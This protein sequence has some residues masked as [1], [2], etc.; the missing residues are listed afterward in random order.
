MDV[1]IDKICEAQQGN[2]DAMLYLIQKYTPLLMRYSKKIY[3]EDAFSELTLAFIELIYHIKIEKLA[4]GSDGVITN[5][6]FTSIKNTYIAHIKEI[7]KE[8][9][10]ITTLDSFTEKDEFQ[11]SNTHMVESSKSYFM[12]FLSDF[13]DLTRKEKKVLLLIYYYGY[14]AAE[15]ADQ[16]K[17]SRQN[18]NQIKKRAQGKIKSG[19]QK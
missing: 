7:M 17:T 5:Y 3:Q 11:M 12:D 1:L 16:M 2:Q 6:I 19:L 8:K 9:G 4:C 15:V 18:I 10:L 14:S 13:P